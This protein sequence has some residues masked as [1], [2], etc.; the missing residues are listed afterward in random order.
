MGAMMPKTR[1]AWSTVIIIGSLAYLTVI[2][3]NRRIA[4][5]IA[6]AYVPILLTVFVV[7]ETWKKPQ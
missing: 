6:L 2:L 4:E 5:G 7:N 1:L 3:F